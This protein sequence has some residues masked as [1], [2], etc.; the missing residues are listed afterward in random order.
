MAPWAWKLKALLKKNFYE[1]KRNIFSTLIEI[2]FPIIVILL[3]YSLKLI[4][5]IKNHDFDFQEGSLQNFTKMRSVFNSDLYPELNVTYNITQ[6][7][8]NPSIIENISIITPEIYGMSI[9]PAFNICSIFNKKNEIRP[10]IATIGVPDEIKE[11]MINESIFFSNYTGFILN[12]NSFKDFKNE[13]EMNSYVGSKDYGE[14]DD[15]P[16]ICFGI[17]FSQNRNE[18]KYD[19]SLH[20]FD[21]KNQHALYD[22]PNSPYLNNYFQTVPD[23]FSYTKYQYNGYTYIMKLITDYIYSQE[24]N[25]K[26]KINFGILPMKYNSYKYDYFLDMVDETL[27]FFI[28]V[29]YIS[30]LGLYVYRMVLEKEIKVKEGMKIMGLTDGIYFLSYFIQYIIIS[31]FESII[32]TFIFLLIFT[33]IP[34]IVIF[35]FLFLFS[36]N[37]FALAFCF[38]S[39]IERTKESFLISLM[40]YFI[41]FFFHMM[42]MSENASYSMKVGLSLFPPVTIYLTFAL[43]GKFESNFTQFYLKDIFCVYTNYSIFTMYIILIVDCIIYLFI[44]YYLQNILKHEF[45]I[46]KPWYFLFTP[47]YWGYKKKAKANLINEDHLPLDNK[48]ELLIDDNENIKE[49]FQSEEIYEVMIDPK[50]SIKIREIVKQYDDGKIA[51]NR[52]SFNLYKNEIFALLG[53]NGSGKTT[54]ISILTG[55]YEATSGEIFYDDMNVLLPEN[56]SYFR[57]KIGICPQHDVLF[58]DL[59]IREHLEIFSVFKG[60]PPGNAEKEISKIIKD[61]QLEDAQYTLAKHLSTGQKR[62]LSIGISLIGGSE[63]IFLDEPSSGM[64]ITSSRNLWE[65]LRGQCNNKIII[66]TTHFM[67]EASILGKRI[68]IINSGKMKCIGTPLFLIEKLGKYMNVT[69]KKEEG[70]IN[71]DIYQFIKTL[72]GDAKF[73]SLSGDITVKINKNIFSNDKNGISINK[74]FEELDNH[75]SILKIKSYSVSMPTLEDVF[76]NIAQENDKDKYCLLLDSKK[77]NDTDLYGLNFLNSFTPF[78]KF[79]F[80]IKLNLIRRF[81]L[82]FRDKKGL[83]VEIFCPI[84]LVLIGCILSKGNLYYPTP[85]FGPKDIH[86][87]GRQI[88]YYSSLNESINKEGYYIGN[89]VNVTNQNLTLFDKDKYI[90]KENFNK[91]LA[92][93]DF[94]SA[95]YNLSKNSEI[96]MDKDVYI[97]NENYIGHYGNFLLL[98]EPNENNTNYEFVVLINPRVKQAVPLFTSSFLEQIIKK[99]SNNKVSINYQHKVFDITYKQDKGSDYDSD[100]VIIFVAVAYALIPSNIIAI[101]VR[102]RI[103]NSKHLMKLSGMNIIS[104]WLVNFFYEIIKYY[105][106]GGICLL[107]IYLFD[108]YETFLIDFYLLYGP[109]LILMTYVLSFFFDDESDAQFKI[110]LFHSLFGSLGSMIIVLFRQEEKTRLLGKIL[111]FFL[112]LIPSFT[113]IFSFNLSRNSSPIL[114]LDYF[115]K[116]PSF[117]NDVYFMMDY[118]LLL[119]GPFCFLVLDIIIYLA[120]LILIEKIFNKEICFKNQFHVINNEEQRDSDVI[121]EEIKAQTGMKNNIINEYNNGLININKDDNYVI[122]IKNLQKIYNSIIY[123]IFFCFKKNKNKI[124]IKNLSLCLE[125]GECFGL[126]GFNGAGK[127]TVFK[128]IT[129]EINPSNGEIFIDGIKTNDNLE[130]IKNKFGYC[131]QYDAIFEY[132]TVYENLEFYAKLKGVKI[133]YMTQIINDAIYQMKLNEFSKKLAKNLSGGNKRK[134][135]FAISML[136]SP[137]I[138]LLDEPSKG[139]DPESKRYMWYIIHKLSTKKTK[140]R[141]PTMIITT[142]SMDEAETLCNRMGI[143]VNGEFACLGKADEIKNKYGFGYELNL[144]IKPLSEELEEELFFSKYDIDKKLKVNKVNIESILKKINKINYMDEIQE[145]RLGEKLTK[146]MVKENQININSLLSWIFYVQNAIKFIHYGKDNFDEIIIE[147]NIENNFLFKFKKKKENIKSIGYIFSIFESYKEE[148]Y[149]TEYS[150]KQTS[151]ESIFNQFSEKP[152]SR[153]KERI[154]DEIKHGDFEITMNNEN[155]AETFKFKKII[156]TDELIFRLIKDD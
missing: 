138:I 59:N 11:K 54:L 37:V 10:L 137:P 91:S 93:Y 89:M 130:A 132:M 81:Y 7:I 127:T 122:R 51:V 125:K 64:D 103:N 40:L 36:I 24:I 124:V 95:I 116:I 155:K 114:L 19:Y 75:L 63:I 5:D 38:Q 115:D 48:E 143:M 15:M 20:Y 45:G 6:V 68:G 154:N 117:A 139:M 26:T 72:V 16:K 83:F 28:M 152:N 121:K 111:E 101:I 118:F 113:F 41:M 43:L 21:N 145:G 69:L 140:N 156:L 123:K 99:A 153:F 92:V 60:V 8:E 29:A 88:I 70:A 55:L 146:R 67:E 104:Y 9:H 33:R 13:D 18:H 53:H 46:R 142:H 34:F 98:N 52:V 107:I 3:F 66:L 77:N 71:E 42:V 23:L 90:N 148:C 131:P 47:E 141:K 2:F 84:I 106:T 74:F 78:Q 31:F 76:L 39:F 79:L 105:F 12:N 17:S 126:L 62:K 112:C 82:T 97:N 73:E 61:F 35:L 151:L 22:V 56:I 109:P 102:E 94:I 30:N 85:I 110:I 44:G 144:K 119:L 149:I 129:Q 80:D 58:K 150:L 27:S 120:L 87:L 50:D 57:E 1:M 108:Y 128:C 86:T 65:I 49:N 100:G 25:N 136:C 14:N 4:Y 147:E 134:L 135:T 96:S 32:L 133:D